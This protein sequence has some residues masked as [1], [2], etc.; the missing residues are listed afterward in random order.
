[1]EHRWGRRIACGAPARLSVGAGI[2]GA[3]QLRDVSLSGAFIETVLELPLFAQVT[4]SVGETEVQASVVRIDA[5]GVGVEWMETEQRAICPLL[6]C[7]SLC[8]AARTAA[9]GE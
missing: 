3:G 4:V 7:V 9:R 8:A 2:T 1:M 5:D 6:G